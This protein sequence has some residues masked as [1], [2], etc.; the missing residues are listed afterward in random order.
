[1]VLINGAP[2][3][4]FRASRGLIQGFPLALFLFLIVVK[5]LSKLI[6]DARIKI[7]LCGVKLE[8]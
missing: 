4:F 5:A 6:E 3:R 2:S 8:G 7:D 1:M